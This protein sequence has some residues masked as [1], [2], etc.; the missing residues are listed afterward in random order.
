M[1]YHRYVRDTFE[2]EVRAL[3][4][5]KPAIIPFFLNHERRKLAEENLVREIKVTEWKKGVWL[6][7]HRVERITKAAVKRFCDLALLK[8]E[9]ELR[10]DA[11]NARLDKHA[12]REQEAAHAF[13]D[14]VKDGIVAPLQHS[15]KS[16][17]GS[18]ATNC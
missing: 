17:G 13:N 15:E 16:L 4:A 8:K 9:H 3:F 7:Q 14:M 12:N 11:E 1:D 5:K 10:S 6:N 2:K 18:E